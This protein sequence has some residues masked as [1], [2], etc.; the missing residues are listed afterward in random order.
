MA[1]PRSRRVFLASAALPLLLASRDARSAAGTDTAPLTAAV[2]GHTGRG[3]YGHGLDMI[4]AGRPGVSL[5][6]VADPEEAGRRAAM[7]RSGA[8]RSYADY[9]ELLEKERPR[10]VSVAMRHADQHRDIVVDCLNAGAHVYLEKPIGR[11][12]AEADDMLRLAVAQKLQVAVAHTMRMA[13]SVVRLRAALRDGRLG[14]LREIRAFGKQDARAGG[15]DMMVLGTHLFDLC[16]A[17]AGDPEWVSGRV[18]VGGRAARVDDRRRVKDDVGWVAGNQVF[19][20][21][22]FGRGVH[23]TFTSDG[24]LREVTGRWGLEVHGTKAT[25]RILCDINPAVLIRDTGAWA[26]TGREDRWVTLAS[27]IARDESTHN[28]GPVSDWLE[29]I[30]AAREPECSARNAAWAVEMAMGVYASS[31]SGRTLPFPL[32]ERG[33]PLG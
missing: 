18:L 11:T 4:F 12:A 15:E 10:L 3:D 8:P 31:L 27:D 1:K 25:A 21:F 2:I 33:H 6:A 30:R 22:G 28:H 9:R 20:T 14:D 24:A 26:P 32:T 16:R 23:A 17:L 13:P 5:L 7:K 19:A 29:A